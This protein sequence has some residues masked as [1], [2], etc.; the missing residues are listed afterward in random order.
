[1]K[2]FPMILAFVKD[3]NFSVRIESAAEILGFEV[4]LFESAIQIS[5]EVDD[6]QEPTLA[7]PLQG[8]DGVLIEKITRWR[9]ALIIFDLGND[10]IPWYPWITMLTSVPAT[11]GIPVLCYGSHVD[12]DDLKAAKEAG[13]TRVVTRST[14]VKDL[15]D[16]LI[17]Q[18]K[19]IDLDELKLTCDEPLSHYALKGLEKFNRG[20]YFKAHDL[21]EI[22]WKEDQSSGRELYRAILQVAVAY[23]QIIRGN[24]NGAAKMF[25]RVRKWLEP[26]PEICR[27][28]NI[29]KLRQEA[30]KVYQEMI[31]LGPDK[32]SEFDPGMMKPIEF[33]KLN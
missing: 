22:A 7:E 20:E 1:M 10:S 6:E 9:P 32:I 23:Y 16:L 27:G 28:I 2:E 24:Y 14:F 25:L 3:L 12:I 8:R 33:Q 5:P 15:S 21:L 13:A 29:G 19:V 26:L 30:G 17:K 4:L 18:A 11:R 31:N